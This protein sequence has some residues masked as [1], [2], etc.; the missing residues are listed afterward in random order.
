[1]ADLGTTFDALLVRGALGALGVAALWLAFVVV[2]VA[3]EARTGGRL[4][5]AEHTGCP[6]V[7]RLWLLAL[8]VALF[9]GIAP[10]QASQPPASQH[11]A[12]QPP[13]GDHSTRPRRAL[14]SEVPIEG[15]QLPDRPET[16]DRHVVV[17]PGDTLWAIA[18]EQVLRTT[19]AARAPSAATVAAAV[20]RL[21][22]ANR[23][24][25]GRDPDLIRPG[26]HL[27]IPEDT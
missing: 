23:D 24:V 11:R 15:L 2:A 4:Q 6:P 13:A 14:L 19:S 16:H 5:L 27:K 9:A 3:V 10:A 1:M 8:F 12:S 17:R 26:Q 22:A 25:I 18:R 21:H 7:L 20:A